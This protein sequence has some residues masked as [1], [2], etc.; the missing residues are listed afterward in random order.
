MLEFK[1][2]DRLTANLLRHANLES[3][4]SLQDRDEDPSHVHRVLGHRT[5]AENVC[6]TAFHSPFIS[7]GVSA[8]DDAP[9]SAPLFSKTNGPSFHR[10][11]ND[12]PSPAATAPA[13]FLIQ[14]DLK[15]SM[16]R[17]PPA[18]SSKISE[19]LTSEIS[20][21]RGLIE[22]PSIDT[23]DTPLASVTNS[24]SSQESRVD[25]STGGVASVP[26][27]AGRV[28]ICCA[29]LFHRLVE[30]LQ[31]HDHLTRNAVVAILEQDR[32]ALSNKSSKKWRHLFSHAAS[33]G[34]V[35]MSDHE[36][37]E[38]WISLAPTWRDKL[39]ARLVS[40]EGFAS[41]LKSDDIFRHDQPHTNGAPLVDTPATSTVLEGPSKCSSEISTCVGTGIIASSEPSQ[42]N[43][44]FAEPSPSSSSSI[45]KGTIFAGLIAQIEKRGPEAERRIINHKLTALDPHIY[46][47]AGGRHF[48]GIRETGGRSRGSHTRQTRKSQRKHCEGEED[49]LSCF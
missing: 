28:S 4:D 45:A 13:S 9:Q 44:T 8:D 17:T 49:H 33:K 7:K 15:V 29:N 39:G 42:G 27:P 14:G 43:P 34:I 1:G 24:L 35:V 2:W 36:K 5:S 40:L 11:P 26:L 37:S 20:R 32:R 46:A 16:E 41:L 47:K 10:T 38:Q 25:G 19:T 12:S 18:A 31:P 3:E 48:R 22:K 21:T 23:S 6:Q 30:I